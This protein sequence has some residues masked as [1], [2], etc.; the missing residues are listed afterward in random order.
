M[1]PALRRKSG[2]ASSQAKNGTVVL[3]PADTVF[4]ER[5]AHAR[6]RRRAILGPR[7]Q[8]RDHRVVEDRHVEPGGRAAVV[9]NARPDGRAQLENAARRRQ[10]TCCRDPR[11]RSGTRWRARSASAA[12]SGSRSSRSPRA[13]RIC[14]RTRSTPVTISVI[15]MLDLQPRVHLEEIEP[16]VLVEQELDR[17]GVGVADRRARP[18]PPPTVMA[19]AAPA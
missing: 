19:A 15:G 16:A 7:H 2:C 3:M 14:H 8:L 17:A 1:E 13:M 18:R 12:A 6:D 10:E 4:G 9:A 11:R 5:A